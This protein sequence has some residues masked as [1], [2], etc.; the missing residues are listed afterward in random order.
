MSAVLPR[1][2]WVR[3]FGFDLD[4]ERCGMDELLGQLTRRSF[5][6]EG[7]VITPPAEKTD[8]ALP[9]P[10]ALIEPG[11]RRIRVTVPR[12]LPQG[13]ITANRMP[14]SIRY[15]RSQVAAQASDCV[16]TW[17]GLWFPRSP[18]DESNEC[19]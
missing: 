4:S 1:R 9:R 5:A 15:G 19:F 13:R 17:Q 6:R 12:D 10:A 8:Q 2:T 11:C 16:F 18:V 7:L 14:S 3:N